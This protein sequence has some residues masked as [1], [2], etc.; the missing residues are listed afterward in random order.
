MRGPWK[1]LLQCRSAATFARAQTQVAGPQALVP[2]LPTLD[3]AQA[4]MHKPLLVQ[5]E[6]SP[7]DA[8]WKLLLTAHH[9]GLEQRLEPEHGSH[10][11][12]V[13]MHVHLCVCVCTCMCCT[14]EFLVW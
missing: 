1:P 4:P 14:P 11:V 6:P 8:S 10:C 9:T 5:A 12:C 7:S 13:S 3:L 2:L